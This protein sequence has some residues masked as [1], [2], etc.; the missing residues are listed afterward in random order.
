MLGQMNNHCDSVGGCSYDDSV[1]FVLLSEDQLNFLKENDLRHNIATPVL[2]RLPTTVK[3]EH[4]SINIDLNVIE[5]NEFHGEINILINV[6]SPVNNL[7]LHAKYLKINEINLIFNNGS[8]MKPNY[9]SIDIKTNFFTINFPKIILTGKYFLNLQYSGI[10]STVIYGNRGF[11]SNYNDKSSFYIMTQLLSI[12]ARQ[13]F[14]CWDEPAW[15]AS[16]RI[17]VKHNARFTALSNMHRIKIETDETNTIQTTTF[18]NTPKMSTHSVAIIVA[19]L[20]Y[21]KSDNGIIKLWSKKHIINKIKSTVDVAGKIL[22]AMKNFT[23]ISYTDMGLKELDI[24]ILPNIHD[25]I[26]SWGLIITSKNFITIEN[27]AVDHTMAENS[28]K[29]LC[30]VCVQQ[31]FG[32]FVTVKWWSDLWFYNGIINYLKF[33]ITEQITDSWSIMDR[34]I[35]NSRTENLFT[36]DI[37]SDV[38]GLMTNNI[39]PS[40]LLNNDLLFHKSV[41]IIYMAT[42]VFG[43]A[44][45][46]KTLQIYLQDHAFE[47]ASFD[48]F[49]DTLIRINGNRTL[50]C[51]KILKNWV[52]KPGFP[53]I[54]VRRDYT[55]GTATLSQSRFL[56]NHINTIERNTTYWVPINY[57]IQ[58]NINFQSSAIENWLNPNGE[59][60]EINGL[61]EDQWIIL[62]KKWFGYYCVN[63]DVKNWQLIITA[64]KSDN[65]ID[66]HVL[67]RAQI[68]YDALK[69]TMNN[70]LDYGTLMSLIGY[71]KHETDILPW[72]IIWDH[73]FEILFKLIVTKYYNPFLE[74]A[75]ELPNK[76]IESIEYHESDDDHHITKLYK[77]TAFIS[78]CSWGSKSCFR[79]SNEIL[80]KWLENPKQV[81]IPTA[82]SEN[83]LCY[84]VR[85]GDQKIWDT[86]MEKWIIEEDN[87]ILYALGCS[88]NRTNLNKLLFKIIES[89]MNE[90]MIKTVLRAISCSNKISGQDIIL[91][92]V[93]QNWR[94]IKPGF[95]S[96]VFHY[97]TYYI[98]EENRF[99]KINEFLKANENLLDKDVKIIL[100][101]DI[102]IVGQRIARYNIIIPELEEFFFKNNSNIDNL[103]I[104]SVTLVK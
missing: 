19:D 96:I 38:T 59:I 8:I 11:V 18:A 51:K 99:N 34:I 58:G 76:L 68:L 52:T 27:A 90:L 30:Y 94:S 42:Q 83:I 48:D 93:I 72:I 6:M 2:F 9:Y 53:I 85:G 79:K 66:I 47:T 80:T 57:A 3:P 86:L 69:L 100:Q 7:T 73:T 49:V 60:I 44:N 75:S 35:I 14:P 81:L 17:I 24:V 63:Y 45:F 22:D 54:T 50:S 28:I 36:S 64:L 13:V 65:Y 32:N 87:K 23:S 39:D 46:Q 88:S 56:K 16:F 84:G 61:Q 78:A 62:N 74:Y 70:H 15:K 82:L 97:V 92:F 101:K 67:N 103:K 102:K 10:I 26:V 55:A 37:E 40:Y 12:G 33:V 77:N 4:Y 20:V 25:V 41:S 98:T 89:N 71:L 104:P 91:D 1:G 43:V 29:D 95:R 31:W 5:N 21:H